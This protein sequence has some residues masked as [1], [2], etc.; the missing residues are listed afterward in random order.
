M[1]LLDDKGKPTPNTPS[2]WVAYYIDEDNNNITK[3]VKTEEN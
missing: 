2:D 3:K 1:G